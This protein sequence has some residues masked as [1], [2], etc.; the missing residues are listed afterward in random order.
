MALRPLNKNAGFILAI[1]TVDLCCLVVI[2]FSPVPTRAGLLFLLVV[3]DEV[4]G[5]AGKRKCRQAKNR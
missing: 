3:V 1:R 2:V 4:V 5:L